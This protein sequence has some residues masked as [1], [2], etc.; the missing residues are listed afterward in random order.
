MLVAELVALG[1]PDVIVRSMTAFL[2]ERR[3]RVKIGDVLSDWLQLSA[4]M[5]QGSYLGPLTFVILIN[6]LQPVCLTHK[7]VDDT[8]MTEFLSRS[9]VSS[10]QLFVDELV[11]Q[12][13]DVGMIVNGRKTKELL[14]SSAVKDLPPPVNLSVE[15]VKSFKLMSVHV[16]SDLRWSQHID[17]I[18]SKAE[19]RLHFL[20]QLKRSGAGRDDL[21]YFYVTVIRTVLEVRLSCVPL[22]S[23]R[24]TDEGTGVAAAQSDAGHLSSFISRTTTIRCRASEPDS[25]RWS[26]VETS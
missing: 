13:T 5:P 15:S 22:Q 21:L 24:C 20:K 7:Y 11:Q 10:M 9:A 14:I 8:T 23:H 17:A 19:S 2:Q 25:K 3:Q 4:G 12:A 1:L 26:H 16:A 18:A 6:A